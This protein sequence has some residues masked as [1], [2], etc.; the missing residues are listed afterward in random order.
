MTNSKAIIVG[1][2]GVQL[3]KL[4]E[5]PTPNLDKLNLIKSFTGGIRGTK[6]E[7]QTSSGANWSTILTGVWANKHGIVTNDKNLRVNPNYPSIFRYIRDHDPESY[8]ASVINWG[9]IHHYFEKDIES[10]VNFKL[11]APE[12]TNDKLAQDSLITMKVAD[13]ISNKSPDFTFVHFDN[14][15]FVGHQF[16]FSPEYLEA[17]AQADAH[18]GIILDAVA[19][20]TAVNTDEDWLIIVTTDHGR[21]PN[22]GFE[23]GGKTDSERTTWIASNQ[24]LDD[25]QL[26]SAIDVVPTVLN[27]FDIEEGGF[28][29]K[30]L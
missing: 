13:L 17:I 29:G 9:S 10:I 5:T 12:P 7:Q 24:E 3:E 14:V 30:S 21:E 15:D 20:R 19:K 25:S 28:D 1:I 27:H 16:G 4:G 18:V 2:D 23:H 26:A 8:L 6:S 11:S 22:D